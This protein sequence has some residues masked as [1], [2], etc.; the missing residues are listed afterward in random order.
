MLL[1]T[2]RTRYNGIV[3]KHREFRFLEKNFR[4]SEWSFFY[5]EKVLVKIQKSVMADSL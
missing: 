1:I 3:I 4:Y 5:E 2:V